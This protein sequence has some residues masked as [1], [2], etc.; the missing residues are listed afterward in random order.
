MKWSDED[1]CA[2]VKARAKRLGLTLEEVM[3][4]AGLTEDPLRRKP[5][6]GRNI[7]SIFQIAEA[8]DDVNPAVLMGLELPAPVERSA[9]IVAQHIVANFQLLQADGLSR[10]DIEKITAAVIAAL[11]EYDPPKTRRAK[12]TKAETTG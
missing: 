5:A 4:R 10:L 8:L 1:F 7:S 2:R 3:T 9:H 12:A 11:R 6:V